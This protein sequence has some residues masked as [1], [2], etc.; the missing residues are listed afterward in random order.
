MT[1]MFSGDDPPARKTTQSLREQCAA[2]LKAFITNAKFKQA[3][4]SSTT[5]ACDWGDDSDDEEAANDVLSGTSINKAAV[6]RLGEVGAIAYLQS[7]VAVLGFEYKDANL[8]VFSGNGCFNIVYFHPSAANP[9]HAILLEAKGGHSGLGYRDDGTGSGKRVQQG[10]AEYAKVIMGVM[11]AS[12]NADRAVA[13]AALQKLANFS[14]ARIAYI[15]VRT[16]Y[17]A[18]KQQVHNPVAIFYK[19]V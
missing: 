8:Q 3:A 9:T 17:D 11:A 6:E 18:V 14:P 2:D 10:S 19:E 7:A 13:G 4:P 16:A 12:K 5:C 1:S 15:G